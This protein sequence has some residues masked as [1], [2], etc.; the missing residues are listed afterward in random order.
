MVSAGILHT[1]AIIKFKSYNF[2]QHDDFENF[3]NISTNNNDQ[4]QDTNL[5]YNLI[6]D[7]DCFGENIL[8]QSDVPEFVQDVVYVSTGYWHSCAILSEERQLS[9]WG[10]NSN[11]ETVVPN[12]FKKVRVCNSK[13]KKERTQDQKIYNSQYRGMTGSYEADESRI[14]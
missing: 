4:Y 10:G 3:I 2:N 5:S 8:G 7:L 14:S 12:E 9:C 13:H 11:G 6:S 1:C